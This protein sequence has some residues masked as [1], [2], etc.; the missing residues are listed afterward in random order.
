MDI[1]DTLK[2]AYELE[3]RLF[4]LS[5]R[6][7]EI[8]EAVKQAKFDLREARIKQAE[9]NGFRALWDKAAGRYEGKMEEL[10]ANLRR[11]EEKLEYLLWRRSLPMSR[12]AKVFSPLGRNGRL[13]PWRSRKPPVFGHSWS[14]ACAP[15]SW[16]LCWK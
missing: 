9:Y 3:T 7:R 2:S 6:S 5:L 4:R 8:G 10:N 12:R 15:R 13:L 11:A 16:R 1:K 14:A